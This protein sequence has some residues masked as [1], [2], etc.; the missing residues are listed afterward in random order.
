[1]KY[2]GSWDEAKSEEW[3]ENPHFNG[4]EGLIPNSVGEPS[5]ILSFSF[6]MHCLIVI[7]ENGAVF[8]YGELKD[9][10]KNWSNV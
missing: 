6:D 5:K 7:L 2:D 3:K 10:L 1:M 9:Q 8:A 4:K